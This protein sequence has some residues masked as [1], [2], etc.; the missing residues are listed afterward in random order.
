MAQ[1]AKSAAVR[2]GI[3]EA[4][5]S[6]FGDSGFHGASMAEIARRA[7]ISH[8]G[9]LHHFPRK[10]ALLTAVLDLQDRRSAAY[11]AEHSAFEPGSDPLVLLRGM[12]TALIDRDRQPGLVELT[13]VL[14]GEAT[15]PGHPA[16][17]YFAQR[18]RNIRSFMTRLFARL[19]DEGRLSTTLPADALAALVI[20]A[21]DGLH[22]QWLY[23]RSAIDV[24]GTVQDFFASLVPELA[25]PGPA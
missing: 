14:S 23:D 16:H 22:T 15:R 25:I 2:E 6:A 20:A 24:D 18:Y 17:D 12:A 3:I 1:Y 5:L 4:C 21:M 10:E 19:R 13:A 7:G 8:T 11:L 9:L